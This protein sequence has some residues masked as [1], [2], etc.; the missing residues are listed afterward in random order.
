MT[1]ILRLRVSQKLKTSIH[2]IEEITVIQP[3]V[4][5]RRVPGRINNNY[6]DHYEISEHVGKILQMKLGSVFSLRFSNE[7]YRKV[8]G[9]IEDKMDKLL[10][11]LQH[12]SRIED[13]ATVSIDSQLMTYLKSKP[14]RY[15]L[16]VYQKGFI[17][18]DESVQHNLNT[19]VT[20]GH[21]NYPNKHGATIFVA[22]I[23]KDEEIALYY[24][25][26]TIKN[27]PRS[28]E[29]L[30]Q[31]LTTALTA[32]IEMKVVKKEGVLR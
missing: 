18:S 13:L 12:S 15:Q 26:G 19:M 2:A 22:L 21:R 1:P 5:I 24:D 27:D 32:L 29:S 11:N 7:L 23:D 16:I 30:S 20:D 8:P 6:Y 17:R 25:E 28:E 3:V 10:G 31:M 14:G 4:K 9:N